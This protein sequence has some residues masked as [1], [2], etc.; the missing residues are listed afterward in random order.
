MGLER[1]PLV[2]SELCGSGAPPGCVE[3]PS[4]RC[5]RPRRPGLPSCSAAK[6]PLSASVAHDDTA[7]RDETD[8]E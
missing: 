7:A 6:R 3:Q 8:E 1:Q 4:A 5:I 2:R